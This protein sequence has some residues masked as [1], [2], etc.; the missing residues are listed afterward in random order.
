MIL[1]LGRFFDLDVIA[2]GIE[3]PEQAERLKQMNCPSGQGYLFSRPMSVDSAIQWV[4]LHN[5]Q[6]PKG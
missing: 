3:T 1:H 5:K 6:A 4:K 2:E